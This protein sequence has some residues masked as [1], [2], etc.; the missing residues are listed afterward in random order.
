M[1]TSK[2]TGLWSKRFSTA[3]GWHWK[4]E[5][6]C[7]HENAEQWL[8]VFSKHESEVEFKLSD[9]KPRIK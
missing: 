5:R 6:L 9:K 3:Q 1:D 7:N 2:E 8:S 4:L